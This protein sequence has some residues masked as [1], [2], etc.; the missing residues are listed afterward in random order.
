[1]GLDKI[2]DG[3]NKM[4]KQVFVCFSQ[5]PIAQLSRSE[6]SSNNFDCFLFILGHNLC[7]PYFLV[8]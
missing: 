7:C 5:L 3:I 6:Y 8:V 2:K 1:M 4:K